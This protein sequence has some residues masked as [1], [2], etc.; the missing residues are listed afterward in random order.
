MLLETDARLTSDGAVVLLHDKNVDRTTN[1]KG[2]V[3]TMTLAQVK[4]LDAGY[5]FS[6]DGGKTFPH[7]AKGIT[8]PTLQEVLEAIPDS[9]FLV[10]LKGEPALADAAIAIIKAAHAEQRVLYASFVPPTMDR[11]REI[12]PDAAYCY[13]M[14]NG[15]ALLMALRSPKWADYVPQADM[16]S[17]VDD[18]IPKYKLTPEE[19]RAIQAKGIKFQVH[20]INDPAQMK[21]FVEQGVDS[22]LSDSP[23]LLAQSIDAVRKSAK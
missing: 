11:A 6:T 4:A 23:D 9:H 16:L 14:K 21:A 22:I 7:R 19:I 3:T 5:T 8:I 15:T 10:E 20:T 2:D 13:D 18:M 17:L 1:G 12:A